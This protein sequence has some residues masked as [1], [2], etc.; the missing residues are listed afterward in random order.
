MT[1]SGSGAQEAAVRNLAK[2]RVL[3]C[4]NGAFSKR[5]HEIVVDNGVPCDKLEVAPGQAITVDLV[6]E[7]LGKGDYD[8]ICLT[9]NETATGVMN[10]IPDMKPEITV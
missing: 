2:E 9:M 5:W 6:D 8:A 1:N 10:P 4:V 3:S 7:A